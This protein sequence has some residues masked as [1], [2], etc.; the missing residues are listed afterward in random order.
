MEKSNVELYLEYINGSYCK[1]KMAKKYNLSISVMGA[2]LE[3][4]REE[5][6]NTNYWNL[7]LKNIVDRYNTIT[8]TK[9]I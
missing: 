3:Y 9:Q 1:E 6:R 2:I 8:L 4:G 7:Y 5:H